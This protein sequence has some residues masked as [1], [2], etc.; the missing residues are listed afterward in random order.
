MRVS[1][2]QCRGTPYEIGQLQGRVFAASRRGLSF[3]RS[4]V[5]P[6]SW[7]DMQAEERFYS[8][9]APAILEEIAG[10]ANALDTSLERACLFFGNG[11]SGHGLAVAPLSCHRQLSGVTTISG[12][13]ITVRVLP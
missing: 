11:G 5:G 1:V 13:R 10:I 2:V 8:K 6:P 9:F 4:K 3:R 12:H 7:F